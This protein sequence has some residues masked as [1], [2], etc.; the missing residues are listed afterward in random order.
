[1]LN[2]VNYLEMESIVSEVFLR[3]L[4]KCLAIL[5]RDREYQTRDRVLQSLNV[6][7]HD[8]LKS[9]LITVWVYHESVKS[10]VAFKD[11]LKKQNLIARIVYKKHGIYRWI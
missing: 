3:N 10:G 5:S 4:L 7:Y 1:M 6:G 8:K 9:L 2:M 11:V